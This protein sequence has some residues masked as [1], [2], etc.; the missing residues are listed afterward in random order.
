MALNGELLKKGKSWIKKKE[1]LEVEF[2]DVMEKEN[3][4]S[5]KT[6]RMFELQ[7]MQGQM[8]QLKQQREKTEAKRFELEA[9][10]Q[11]LKGIQASSGKELMI[12]VG[13]GIFVKGEVRDNKTAI[14]AVGAGIAAV[15]SIDSV[16]KFLQEQGKLNDEIVSEL[17]AQM[18][19]LATRAQTLIG[20][21][22]KEEADHKE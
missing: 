9:T 19:K 15:N 21:L 22:E 1:K 17:D 18:K 10:T 16:L 6:M 11:S 7:M 2:G 4:K 20:E 8:D 13:S 5:D 14:Y 3:E 12:P